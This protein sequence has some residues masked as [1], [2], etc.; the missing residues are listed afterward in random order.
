MNSPTFEALIADALMEGFVGVLNR[1]TLKFEEPGRKIDIDVDDLLRETAENVAAKMAE[2]VV[3]SH[4]ITMEMIEDY[5]PHCG[6]SLTRWYPRGWP[7]KGGTA[8]VWAEGGAA[9]G[10]LDDERDRDR[11]RDDEEGA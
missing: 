1:V 2:Y 9:R 5:C 6:N 8:P 4:V 7:W 10:E 11:D 3:E